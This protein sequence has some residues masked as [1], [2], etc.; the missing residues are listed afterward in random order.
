MAI[1]HLCTKI[2]GRSGGRTAT[3]AAAYRAGIRIRDTRTGILFDY[4]RRKN[5]CWRAIAAPD[6]APEWALSREQLWNAV[7]LAEKRGDAQLAR[8]VEISLPLELS[9]LERLALI[10]EFVDA[11]FVKHGM[12]ADITVHDNQGNPHVHILLTMRELLPDGFGKKVREWNDKQRLE[13]WRQAWAAICNRALAKSG[14]RSRIDHRSLTL[15]S[16][17]SINLETMQG[18]T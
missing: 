15:P 3:A 16:G 17:T 7:E 9:Y 12:V 8:E 11:T 6:H 13:A 1:Y 5:V 4:S 2:I 10:A 18:G 14:H